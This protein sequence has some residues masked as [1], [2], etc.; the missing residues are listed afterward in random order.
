MRAHQFFALV[1]KNDADAVSAALDSDPSLIE[2]FDGDHQAIH[3]AALRG[4]ADVLDALMERGADINR[5]NGWGWTPIVLAAYHNH[6]EAVRRLIAAGAEVG[7]NG[8]NP[9][10]YAG[11]NRH[12]EV[13][14]LLVEHGAVDSMVP[15]GDPDALSVFRAAYAYDAHA[16]RQLLN[17]RQE[18]ANARDEC[19]RTPMHEAATA[20]ALEIVETLIEAGGDVNARDE[21]GETPLTRAAAHR[22]EEVVNALIAAG[23][24]VDLFSAVQF[25]ILEE[26]RRL[27]EANPASVHSTRN[28]HALIEWA[29][30]AGF[31]EM[32]RLLAEFGANIDIH[33]AASFGL[34]ERAEQLLDD[35]P[36]LVHARRR[37]GGYAPLH[38]AAECGQAETAA[39]LIQRGADLNQKND[40]GFRP[41][42]LSVLAARGHAPTEAHLRIS[43]AL[44]EN[45]ADLEPEDDYG[46]T[47]LSLAEGH[48]TKG[49]I[50]NALI[51][52]LRN[53]INPQSRRNENS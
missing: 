11:Q 45:G 41:L 13:C 24:R 43:T 21:D 19:E 30:E 20:G 23:A 18:L 50:E 49:E 37:M 4:N 53:S 38:A 16:L 32:G 40:W 33:A 36:D 15:D 44:I 27:L 25:N 47:P 10:H 29:A 14:R 35:D 46:R 17:R 2:A 52:L 12:R 28:G 26:A 51:Q 1:K 6:I 8:G 5:K 31:V 39:L 9:I 7:E 42:H 3:E 22:Q 34:T 48:W